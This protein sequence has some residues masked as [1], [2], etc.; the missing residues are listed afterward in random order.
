MTIHTVYWTDSDG[1]KHEQ[2]F[3][4]QTQAQKQQAYL[5]AM[6]KPH[7]FMKSISAKRRRK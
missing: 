2:S 1:S 3:P 7:V 5:E 4:T 6:G